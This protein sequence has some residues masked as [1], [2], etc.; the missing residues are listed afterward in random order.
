M[1]KKGSILYKALLEEALELHL[2]KNAGYSSDDPDAFSNFRLSEA[3][4]IS[5]FKGVMV[6]LGDKFARVQSLLGNPANEKVGESIRDTLMDLSAYAL[7]G[8]CLMEEEGQ[9][10][11][12]EMVNRT[13]FSTRTFESSSMGYTWEPKCPHPGCLICDPQ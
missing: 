3:I 13:S 12:L 1:M 6:R 11:S 5:A 2:N 4:G 8:I 7:I 9:G 10:K